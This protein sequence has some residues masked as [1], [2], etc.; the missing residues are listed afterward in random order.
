[1]SGSVIADLEIWGPQGSRRSQPP[2]VA[3]ADAYCRQLA[4]SHYENFPVVSWLLPKE[5]HQHFFNVYAFCRWADDLGDEAG[6]TRRALELLQWW[7]EETERCYAG[8]CVHPVFVALQPT[9]DEFQIPRQPFLDLISAFEQDQRVTEY[10]TFDQLRDYCRRSADPVGRLVLLLCRQST[11]EHIAW[12][13]SICTGLQLANF[14]QDVSRD[15]DIGRIYLP[16]EDRERFAYPREDLHRRVTNDAF[17]DLMKFEVDRAGDYLRAGLPLVERL[18]GALQ[19]DIDLFLHGG[20]RILDRI[21]RIGYRVWD[22][23]PKVTKGD[24]FRLLLGCLARRS[25]RA[26]FGRNRR[27][28][29]GMTAVSP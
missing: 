4:T 2:S 21:E 16:R 10:E 3:E 11:P 15:L 7:R 27:F 9:I 25:W 12:S 22:V 6:D 14:W 20:L 24:A 23:R 1:M 5:L 17:L 13:D 28:G 19:I 18:P 29:A 26:L 8:E